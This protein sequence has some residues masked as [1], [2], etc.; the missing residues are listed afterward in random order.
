MATILSIENFAEVNILER[1]KLAEDVAAAAVDVD[2]QNADNISEDD[3]IVIGLPGDESSEIRHVTGGTAPNVTF[4]AL[5]RAHDKFDPVVALRGDKV[6]IYRIAHADIAGS[7]P[8]DAEFTT[9]GVYAT[10][11]LQVDQTWT[12][13]V[14]SSGGS[15]YWYKLTYY[16]SESTDETSLSLMEAVRGGGYLNWVSLEDVRSE[17]GFEENQWVS[18]R[19]ISDA[20]DDAESI[21]KSVLSNA[22]Y[23]LPLDAPIPGIVKRFARQ[24]AAAYILQA[25]YGMDAEGTS[26]DGYKKEEVVMER[27]KMIAK[28]ELALINPNDDEDVNNTDQIDGYPDDTTEDLS[29]SESGGDINFRIGQKF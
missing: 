24:L 15:D 10:V 21:I 11:T 19:K 25:E 7:L 12:E 16:N 8:T 5:S 22:G 17:A 23:D 14:D 20:R 26:K 3:P 28:G 9:E 4:A 18:D 27:L 29:S 2:V 1:T 13:Y 6:R